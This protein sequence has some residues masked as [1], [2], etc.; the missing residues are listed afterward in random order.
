MSNFQTMAEH[1]QVS[2]DGR[3]LRLA[4]N[5]TRRVHNRALFSQDAAIGAQPI[6]G[7]SDANFAFSLQN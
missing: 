3:Y 5:G 4:R 1:V 7:R 2:D 6:D